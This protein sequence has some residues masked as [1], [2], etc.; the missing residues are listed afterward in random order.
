[1]STEARYIIDE[2]LEHDDRNYTEASRGAKRSLGTM[3][4][5][6]KVTN[7]TSTENE[8]TKKRVI[9]CLCFHEWQLK[10]RKKVHY[11]NYFKYETKLLHWF[12]TMIITQY[13]VACVKMLHLYIDLFSVVSVLDFSNP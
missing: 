7:G 4:Q 6:V 12:T 5:A 9:T 2:T 10:E 3:M 1:M 11:Y 13:S 8:L